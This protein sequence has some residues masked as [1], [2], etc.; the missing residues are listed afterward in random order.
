MGSNPTL[1]ASF[2]RETGTCRLVPHRRG[3]WEQDG[4]YMARGLQDLSDWLF[5]EG[6]YAA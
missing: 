3:V 2:E 1:S 6:E 4:R 5:S